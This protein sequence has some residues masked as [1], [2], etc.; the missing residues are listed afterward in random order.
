M[1]QSHGAVIL[2]TLLSF[3]L[4]TA[5]AGHAEA[6]DLEYYGIESRIIDD[7]TVKTSVTIKFLLPVSTFTYDLSYRIFNFS[8][9]NSSEGRCEVFEA[10]DKSKISC[11][12]SGMMQSKNTLTLGFFSRSG[13]SPS[14]GLYNYSADYSVP[15][16]VKSSFVMIRIPQNSFLSDE[17]ANQSYYPSDGKILTDGKYIMVYWERESPPELKF[18]VSYSYSAPNSDAAAFNNLLIVSVAAIVI[19]SMI[20]V[21]FYVKKG[22]GHEVTT[23]VLASVLNTDE[24]KVVDILSKHGGKVGQKVIVR[25]SDFSKAKI[26]RLVKNLK[27]RGVVDIEPISGRENR[28]ILKFDKRSEQKTQAPEAEKVQK[29]PV[30]QT[31][32]YEPESL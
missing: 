26:S 28:I 2:V 12:F 16:M 27:G 10:E 3:A 32:S 6:A 23:E 22:S 1:K 24:M 13:I 14:G 8:Y 19:I 25:E 7:A 4:F 11:T 30:L 29:D 5:L 15:D 9:T 20:S 21:A 17:P 18:S 31:E